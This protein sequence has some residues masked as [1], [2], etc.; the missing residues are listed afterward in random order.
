MAL[1]PARHAHCTFQQN[2][3]YL[4]IASI[5]HKRHIFIT[6]NPVVPIVIILLYKKIWLLYNSITFI[7]CLLFLRKFI[8]LTEHLPNWRTYSYKEDF[9]RCSALGWV[10]CSNEVE[11]VL[12]I[13]HWAK[14]IF[15]CP[16][17]NSRKKTLRG[18]PIHRY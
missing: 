3:Y 8:V 12:F 17:Q 4:L 7:W 14:L 6:Q 1:H 18:Q 10:K 5:P 16:R 13:F 15:N 9:F 2:A 11:T